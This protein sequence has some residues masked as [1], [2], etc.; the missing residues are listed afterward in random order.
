MIVVSISRSSLD[1]TEFFTVHRILMSKRSWDGQAARE[2]S[3]PRGSFPSRYPAPGTS[4]ALTGRTASQLVE[5]DRYADPSRA[6]VV[7]PRPSTATNP[8]IS[9]NFHTRN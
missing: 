2:R 9:P 6:A 1:V 4:T 7:D 3:D 5:L 8:V